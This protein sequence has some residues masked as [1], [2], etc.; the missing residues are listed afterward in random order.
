MSTLLL[1]L[2]EELYQFCAIEQ[3]N[4]KDWIKESE[5]ELY[6]ISNHVLALEN[7]LKG[8]NKLVRYI[9]LALYPIMYDA[10]FSQSLMQKTSRRLAS[11]GNVSFLN[12][13]KNEG[14]SSER[15]G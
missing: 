1:I 3:L 8:A 6:T 2:L 11:R 5:E 7:I 14:A 10:P 12:P 15:R 9:F 4:I 13:D